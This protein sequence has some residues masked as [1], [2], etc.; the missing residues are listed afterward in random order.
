ML[1]GEQ[2]IQRPALQ[3]RCEH[4]RLTQIY[5]MLLAVACCQAFINRDC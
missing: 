5:E 3:A 2:H 4:L 1:T